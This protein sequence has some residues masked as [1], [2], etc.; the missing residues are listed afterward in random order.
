MK[1]I[2]SLPVAAALVA[3][4]AGV[5][6][7]VPAMAQQPEVPDTYT[8]VTTNMTP[9]EVELKADVLDWSDEAGRAAVIAALTD[10]EDP[11]EALRTLPTLGVVWRSGSA[12]GHAIKYAHR[13]T[14]ADGS[15][16]ITL[17]TDKRIG[18]TSF[19]PWTADGAAIDSPPDYSVVELR[20]G[21]GDGSLSLAAEVVIDAEAGLVA[22]AT[23]SGTP[24]LT[25]V[26]QAPKPY[27][28]SE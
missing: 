26:M 14:A 11:I 6:L 12:V 3:A 4:A 23:D 7:S 25:S 10:A 13:V 17:V 5:A 18:S 21:T 2:R 22:L 9:A 1:T 8:A 27:W 28:A 20:T 15:E 19:N 24:V 16:T